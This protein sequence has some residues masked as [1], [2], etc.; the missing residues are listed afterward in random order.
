MYGATKDSLPSRYSL[1]GNGVDDPKCMPDEASMYEKGSCGTDNVAKMTIANAHNIRQ[2]NT[3]VS[4]AVGILY[5]LAIPSIIMASINTAK[6]TTTNN[7]VY[8]VLK[9]NSEHQTREF[10]QAVATK[11]MTP[12]N[13]D[14]HK[15]V[16]EASTMYKKFFR[17]E[18]YASGQAASDLSAVHT[19]NGNPIN[20]HAF[21]TVPTKCIEEL[22][23]VCEENDATDSRYRN[24]CQ[25]SLEQTVRE[26]HDDFEDDSDDKLEEATEKAPKENKHCWHNMCD[27][28]VPTTD[29]VGDAAGGAVKIVDADGDDVTAGSEANTDRSAFKDFAYC[30]YTVDSKTRRLYATDMCLAPAQVDETHVWTATAGAA[31][32]TSG[33]TKAADARYPCTCYEYQAYDAQC[34]KYEDDEYKTADSLYGIDCEDVVD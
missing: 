23:Q 17:D 11:E 12:T 4:W 8:N 29:L 18:C 25:V 32:Y 30:T 34:T 13:V 24:V 26:F 28:D 15:F 27:F 9:A 31:D 20:I 1:M 6:T 19:G 3:N 10:A 14:P 7:R 5:L 22:Y 2:I 21:H 16:D 33:Y